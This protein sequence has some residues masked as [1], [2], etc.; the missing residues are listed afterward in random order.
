MVRNDVCLQ[1]GMIML[2]G[3]SLG[4]KLV[5]EDGLYTREEARETF[6]TRLIQGEQIEELYRYIE[7]KEAEARD[8]GFILTDE[9]FFHSLLEMRGWVP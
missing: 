7:E 4:L 3:F 9:H 6:N 5:D 1:A 2:P 8:N